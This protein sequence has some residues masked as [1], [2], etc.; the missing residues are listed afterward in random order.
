MW[1]RKFSVATR[2][3]LAAGPLT[4][5]EVL[6]PEKA[7]SHGGRGDTFGGIEY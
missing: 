1:V 4:E 5:D 3:E 7:G 6:L 2:D